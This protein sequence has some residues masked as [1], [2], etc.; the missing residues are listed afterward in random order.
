MIQSS[1]HTPFKLS[2]IHRSI[3]SLRMAAILFRAKDRCKSARTTRRLRCSS[4]TWISPRRT[5]SSYRSTMLPFA[6]IVS[7]P[8]LEAESEFRDE[9]RNVRTD[10]AIELNRL[11][12]CWTGLEIT[13]GH[14]S[15]LDICIRLNEQPN[16]LIQMFCVLRRKFISCPAQPIIVGRCPGHTTAGQRALWTCEFK[17]VMMIKIF[18]GYSKPGPFQ[19]EFK[20]F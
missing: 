6:R 11:H 5:I 10:S 15:C 14:K 13:S 18:L 3:A 19:A 16:I 12:W 1:D 9:V 4:S 2:G 8:W 7:G 20:E 17:R